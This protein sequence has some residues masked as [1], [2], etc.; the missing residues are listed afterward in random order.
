MSD[1]PRILIADDDAFIR[2]PLEWIL[3]LEGFDA[4][5]VTD[6]DECIER[7]VVLKRRAA[8]NRCIQ[9]CSQTV[10]I[11]SRRDL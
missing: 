1:K 6:G 3:L 2:R 7:V 11:G 8:Q 4:E 5:T 9:Q 10:H